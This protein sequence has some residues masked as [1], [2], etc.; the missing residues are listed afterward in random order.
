MALPEGGSII[1]CDISEPWTA[2]ARR[3]WQEAGIAHKIDLRL[4]PAIRTL[5]RLLEDGE[6]GKFD[7]AFIDADKVSYTDYYERCLKLIRPG[8]LIA[9]DNTLWSGRV[10]DAAVAD[11]DT[12]ALQKFN[13]ELATDQRVWM[14]LLPMG[15]GLTLVVK[16]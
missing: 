12:V 6:A 2:I 14:A 10:A 1:A 16:R 4:Q 5:D 9:V 8:G 13:K 11:D 3:Y 7:F 15:D